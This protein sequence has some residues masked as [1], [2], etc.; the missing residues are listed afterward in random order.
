MVNINSTDLSVIEDNQEMLTNIL[1]IIIIIIVFIIIYNYYFSNNY[2]DNTKYIQIVKQETPV[3]APK[4]TYSPID[5]STQSPIVTTTSISP[6]NIGD[7]RIDV[8]SS[9]GFKIGM[10]IQI[11]YGSEINTGK[12]T[13]FGSIIIDR[14]VT[15]YHPIN[16]IITGFTNISV[17]IEKSPEETK[18]LNDLINNLF[19]DELEKDTTVTTVTPAVTTEKSTEVI[20]EFINNNLSQP[21]IYDTKHLSYAKN[22]GELENFEN[23]SKKFTNLSSQA[24]TYEIE[25]FVNIANDDYEFINNNSSQSRI[26]EL[27]NFENISK[28]FTNLSPQAGT[29]EIESFVN[30]ASDKYQLI[31]DDSSSPFSINNFTP[32]M[33]S[34]EEGNKTNCN[35]VNSD[36]IKDYKEKYFSKYAHQVSCDKKEGCNQSTDANSI[37]YYTL[38][39]NKSKS[40]VSCTR[41]KEPMIERP[42]YNKLSREVQE[43]DDNIVRQKKI[44]DSNVSNFV[45]FEN[46]VYQNSIGETQVDKMAEI[47]TN[48]GTCGLNNY[49]TT[50]AQIYDNLVGTISSD[51]VYK[52]MENPDLIKGVSEDLTYINH[53]E[54]V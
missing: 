20:E 49:G 28:K 25:S 40:C 39:T 44:R 46:N 32:N 33:V 29:Y 26:Y 35:I 47:R 6:I 36:I 50:I 13:G 30:M 37:N 18:V 54:S 16:T 51:A 27:E 5:L 24:G 52:D 15:Y 41:D 23:I 12:V 22:T 2:N 48:V 4:Q 21:K 31:N 3:I 7:T 8:A 17:P 53:F 9:T 43:M 19:V 38:K 45:N 42:V 1:F 34:M 14:P 10:D 11:G